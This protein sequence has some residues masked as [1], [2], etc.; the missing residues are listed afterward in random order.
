MTTTPSPRNKVQVEPI[1]LINSIMLYHFPG[2]LFKNGVGPP[3]NMSLSDVDKRMMTQMY[4][5]P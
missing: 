3:M 5:R 1:H 2:A 4:P